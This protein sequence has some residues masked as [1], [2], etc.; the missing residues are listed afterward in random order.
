MSSQHAF[1]CSLRSYGRASALLEIRSLIRLPL[2]TIPFLHKYATSLLQLGPAG[3]NGEGG[4][5][6][7]LWVPEAPLLQASHVC[8]LGRF[9]R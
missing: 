3:R 8:L 6:Y 7:E 1:P 9:G 5:G 4:Y 2:P